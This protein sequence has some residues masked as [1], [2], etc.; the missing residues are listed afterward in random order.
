M[1]SVNS[2]SMLLSTAA[3]SRNAAATSARDDAAASFESTLQSITTKANDDAAA[4]ARVQAQVQ[5]QAQAAKAAAAAS[6]GQGSVHDAPKP[7]DEAA[8]ATSE[9]E[10]LAEAV[11]GVIAEMPER[12]AGSLRAL[13]AEMR[14]AGHQFTEEKAHDAVDDLV[15]HGRLREVPGKRGA[16]GFQAVLTAAAGDSE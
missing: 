2:A 16:Q 13:Y 8:S 1:S 11:W 9:A 7:D 15:A 12:T 4:Q 3:Q 10:V 6:A 14:S 5:A